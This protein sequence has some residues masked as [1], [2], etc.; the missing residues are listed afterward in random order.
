MSP[1]QKQN[2]KPERIQWLSTIIE[3]EKWQVH[4]YTV[5]FKVTKD[6]WNYWFDKGI[7]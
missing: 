6:H 3:W 4:S 1:K 5:N 7:K 2:K